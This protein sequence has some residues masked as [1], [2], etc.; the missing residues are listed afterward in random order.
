MIKNVLNRARV[1]VNSVSID[2]KQ[3][4]VLRNLF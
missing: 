1:M 2:L 3:P 4:S